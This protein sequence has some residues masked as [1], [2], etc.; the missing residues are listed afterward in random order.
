MKTLEEIFENELKESTIPMNEDIFSVPLPNGY[1][2]ENVF[3]EEVFAI[4]DIPNDSPFSGLNRSLVFA[5]PKGTVAKRRVI[6]KVNRW[7]CRLH[8]RKG[9]KTVYICCT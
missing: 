2:P 5:L 6:D 1:S 4:K 8:N 3:H 7:V 9:C